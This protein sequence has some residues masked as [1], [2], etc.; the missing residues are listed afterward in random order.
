MSTRQVIFDQLQMSIKLSM[1]NLIPAQCISCFHEVQWIRLL[2]CQRLQRVACVNGAHFGMAFWI[3]PKQ[4]K[5]GLYASN[6][7]NKIIM[8]NNKVLQ[9]F[10][11]INFCNRDSFILWL[12]WLR[13]CLHRNGG[14]Q[15]GEVTRFGGGNPPVHITS[16]NWIWSRLHD[17]WGGHMRDYMDRWITPP[18]RVNSC[19]W[20]SP[21]PCARE[22][23]AHY[24]LG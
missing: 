6:N 7:N 11:S 19:N 9:A 1:T 22:E 13:A 23:E 12:H 8:R 21:P 18:K 17:R 20:S 2:V 24:Q 5:R 15:V 4:K 16:H 14:P 10:S 3:S